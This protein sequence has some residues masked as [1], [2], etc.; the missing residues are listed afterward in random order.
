MPPKTLEGQTLG[1][2]RILDALGR[3]G[4]AQVFR[5]YHPQL[6]RYV[7]LKV[8]RSD[9]V[10]QDDFL[11][12][13]KRE[14]HAVAGLRHPNIVQVFDFDVQ[15]DQHYM[16]MELLEGDTLR[17]RLNEYRIRG[18]RMP[19]PEVLRILVEVLGGLGYAHKEGVIHRDIKPANI[20][21]TRRGQAVLTDFGIAQ[22]VGSTQ[23][24]VSGALMGT[25]NYM[26]PEQ[27]FKGICDERSDIYSLGIVFYEMLTGYTPFDADTPLAILLKH[28][29]DRLP[30][31]S[32]IDPQLPRELEQISLK[33]LAK[34]PSD[35]YQSAEEM[36]NA[37]Q[38]VLDKNLPDSPRPVVPPPSG[39]QAQA[40]F[41]GAARQQISDHRFADADTNMD[42]GPVAAA[43]LPSTGQVTSILRRFTPRP[44]SPVSAVFVSLMLIT[45]INLMAALAGAL[46]K[47]DVFAYGWTLEIFLVAGMLSFIG[48]GTQS[49]WLL[50]PALTVFGHGLLLAYSSL[51]GRWDDWSFLWM[52]VP[53]IIGI[54]IYLPNKLNERPREEI[55]N[56]GRIGGLALGG[57]SM[58]MAGI[59]CLLSILISLFR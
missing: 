17:A 26:A 53:L 54:A 18:Q 15:D 9:L 33:A 24:T 44:I 40:V 52:L 19:L 23:Y 25:L 39:F 45:A 32:Q 5:G 27:G 16:V 21:L 41:S 43:A 51:S 4:M 42:L 2:Y 47:T 57:L 31:P 22:I 49:P 3:G 58:L 34:D 56:W 37:L 29:N 59:T 48:W 46:S 10:E 20:M 38:P 12:R 1:K 8:L 50:V 14:A 28:L 7:A 6:D 30:L 55:P 35:R 11:A 13:F 36:A